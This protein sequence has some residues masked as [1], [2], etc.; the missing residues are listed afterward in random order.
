MD[1]L[2]APFPYFGGKSR[3]A[4][5]VW[6]RFGDPIN[7]VEPFCGSC[8]VLLSRPTKP[9]TETVNDLDGYLVNFWRALKADPDGVQKWCDYP[10]TEIDLHARHKWLIDQKPILEKLKDDP[11]YYDVKIAGWWVWGI[12]CWFGTGWCKSLSKQTPRLSCSGQGTHQIGGVDLIG[13]SKRLRRVRVCCGDWGRV[14][15]PVVTDGSYSLTSVFLDPPY[16]EEANC[17][18]KLYANDSETVAHEVREWALE[19]GDNPKFRIALCGY[20]G[21]HAM[22]ESW[23]CLE[24]SASGGYGKDKENRHRERIWFSPHCLTPATQGDL[25]E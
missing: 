23:E 6:K 2:K 12:S 1:K 9:H 14:L 15:T 21:E 24:W 20:E 10:V 13:L 5:E 25:F 22:P 18:Q 4:A 17:D 11:A 16:S 19:H 7:Y 3:V 8:A